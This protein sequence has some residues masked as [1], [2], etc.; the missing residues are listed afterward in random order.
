MLYLELHSDCTHVYVIIKTLKC[1]LVTSHCRVTCTW[2]L[3]GLTL[4]GP[5]LVPGRPSHTLTAWTGLENYSHLVEGW[6]LAIRKAA[7]ALSRCLATDSADYCMIVNEWV[8]SKS[9][10]CLLRLQSGHGC[11]FGVR[12]WTKIEIWCIKVMCM[13]ILKVV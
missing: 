2:W 10:D 1:T 8:W 9:R 13:F 7:W 6:F 11:S 12:P 5:W 3:L 4:K